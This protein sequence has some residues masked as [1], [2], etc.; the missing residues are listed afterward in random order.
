MRQKKGE[1]ISMSFGMIFSIVLIIIFIAFTFYGIMKFLEFQ[2]TVKISK[3]SSDLQNDID[4]MWKSAQGSQKVSYSLPSKIDAVCFVDDDYQNMLFE[5][6][7]V[8]PGKKINHLDTAKMTEREEQLCVYNLDG[9]VSMV[10]EK[11]YGDA[12]VTISR[13]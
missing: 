12:L 3:F 4:E 1:A 7:N 13:E 5:S 2:D 11:E 8:I 9:K 6:E 10:I